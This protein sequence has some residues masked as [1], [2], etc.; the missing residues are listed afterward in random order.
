MVLGVTAVLVVAA[1]VW[2]WL[3]PTPPKT[4][5]YQPLQSFDSYYEAQHPECKPK[6]LA[7]QRDAALRAK[8]A[9]A[10]GTKRQEA[11]PK[12]RDLMQSLRATNA[13]EEAL[14]LGFWQSKSAL[15]Q[16]ILTVLALAATAW[17]AWAAADAARA[18][19][20]S[21]EDAR[22][23]AEEQTR[24]YTEQLAETKASVEAARSLS[25]TLQRMANANQNMIRGQVSITEAKVLPFHG[26][27]P[28]V[29]SLAFRNT[30]RTRALDVR[31]CG[32]IELMAFPPVEPLREPVA[33]ATTA[34]IIAPD[35]EGETRPRMDRAPTIEE[36]RAMARGELAIFVWG[37]IEYSD[38][39]GSRYVLHYRYF[40]GGSARMNP[41][42]ML[43][44]YIVGNHEEKLAT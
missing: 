31:M 4:P 13:G 35:G 37:R 19:K 41:G 28:W 43:A 9:E 42:L 40:I 27:S 36:R 30:G 1:V 16:A 14:R 26:D 2:V 3:W 25:E 21:V 18:A 10:C 20:A 29:V 38:I 32:R 39:F 34:G 6:A 23:D 33:E 7:A 24:R 44:P 15:I 11:R 22:A 12:Y 5:E 17:A 8:D